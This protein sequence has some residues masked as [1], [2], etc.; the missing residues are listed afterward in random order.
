M[1]KSSKSDFKF[2]VDDIKLGS[3]TYF[4]VINML[5]EPLFFQ[6]FVDDFFL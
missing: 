2:R 5:I 4:Q 6:V 1:V 3:I